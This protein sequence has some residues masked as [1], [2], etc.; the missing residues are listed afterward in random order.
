TGGLPGYVSQVA[1]IPDM[2][3]GVVVLTN[4][5]ESG[6]FTSVTYRLLDDYLGAPHVDWLQAFHNLS[7]QQ[8]SGAE[9]SVS[10]AAEA[11]AKDSKASL[12]LDKYAGHYKD[13]WYGDI[14]IEMENGKL[15][16]RFSHTPALT[17]DLAHWQYDTFKAVWR[18]RSL[19]ADAF[20]TFA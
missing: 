3:L 6:M 4:Q 13:A 8:R 14:S 1:M 19:A 20:V 18:D 12:P 11:R 17:G 9:K 7:Q 15:V 16:M 10:T 2:K 5:E